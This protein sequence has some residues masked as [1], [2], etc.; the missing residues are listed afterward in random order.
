MVRLSH[1]VSHTLQVIWKH[2]EVWE[3]LQQKKDN[4]CL[5]VGM[6]SVKSQCHNCFFFFFFL[7]PHEKQPSGKPVYSESVIQSYAPSEQLSFLLLT[8]PCVLVISCE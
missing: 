6:V 2:V 3:S 1:Q 4:L 5:C 7:W 8:H